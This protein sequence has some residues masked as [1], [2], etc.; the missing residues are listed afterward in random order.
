MMALMVAI[1]VATRAFSSV[2]V[3]PVVVQ[4]TPTVTTVHSGIRE[5]I[6]DEAV[7][8][9]YDMQTVKLD[10]Q[11]SMTDYDAFSLEIWVR[12]IGL[13]PLSERHAKI[14]PRSTKI[15]LNGEGQDLTQTSIVTIHGEFVRAWVENE[16]A[17]TCLKPLM[18]PPHPPDPPHPANDTPVVDWCSDV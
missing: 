4:T 6:L 9:N 18:I 13:D 7:A 1:T 8:P 5:A 12:T 3:P 10:V 16:R 14:W 2:L 17:G 11:Q 15:N